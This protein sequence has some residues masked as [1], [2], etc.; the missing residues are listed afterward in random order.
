[1]HATIDRSGVIIRQR[2]LAETDMRPHSGRAVGHYAIGK[3]ITGV[4]PSAQPFADRARIARKHAALVLEAGKH[5]RSRIG[6]ACCGLAANLAFTGFDIICVSQGAP[7]SAVPRVAPTA[8]RGWEASGV[9]AVF[10]ARLGTGAIES[11]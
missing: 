6:C 5:C 2:T 8:G 10:V 11:R 9:V 1:M 7:S 3:R 4:G